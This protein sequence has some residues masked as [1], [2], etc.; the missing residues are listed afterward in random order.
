MLKV[1]VVYTNSKPQT[2][3]Y[4]NVTSSVS[5][6]NA[7]LQFACPVSTTVLIYSFGT[8]VSFHSV[9]ICSR[10][11]LC[12]ATPLIGFSLPLSMNWIDSHSTP[13]DHFLRFYTVACV[14]MQEKTT[15]NML[16]RLKSSCL[17]RLV[18][19]LS[20]DCV[21]WFSCSRGARW[22]RA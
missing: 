20:L 6:W 16:C 3:S 8:S 21:V 2:V 11:F 15:A 17:F 7:F 4:F 5:L 18:E 10:S 1:F 14:S 13:N 19:F 9:Y 12:S 22:I